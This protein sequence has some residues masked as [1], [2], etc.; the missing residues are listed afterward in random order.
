MKNV[1]LNKNLCMYKRMF[2]CCAKAVLFCMA[3]N[4]FIAC[5]KS[6]EEVV[7]QTES[8]SLFYAPFFPHQEKRWMTFDEAVAAPKLHGIIEVNQFVG[9]APTNE[10]MQ[11]ASDLVEKTLL[12]IKEKR[13]FDL[14][15]AMQLGYGDDPATDRVHFANYSYIFDD[16]SL[17]P[18]APEYLMFYPT[19]KGQHLLV[20]VMF[21]Q[22]DIGTHGEQIGGA[23]T[24]WHFHDYGEGVCTPMIVPDAILLKNGVLQGHCAKGE[25]LLKRSPEMLHVWFVDHPEGRFAT[26][27]SIDQSLVL[28]SP[29]ATDAQIMEGDGVEE[30]QKLL[31]HHH[32]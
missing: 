32:H 7:N 24:V 8:S 22:Q 20:G 6:N 3:V 11:A 23:N 14:K 21:I 16:K 1:Y 13:L 29:F 17:D 18:Q 5:S 31:H 28:S 26:S 9:V 30:R 25:I 10:Q 19:G 2:W 4:L 15:Q 27:M 12:N